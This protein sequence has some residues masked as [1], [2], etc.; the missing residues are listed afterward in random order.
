LKI[1][2][3][4]VLLI[5][6]FCLTLSIPG[7]SQYGNLKEKDAIKLTRQA[8]DSVYN[9]NFPAA[10]KLIR[11]LE[12]GLGDY[13][14][15]LILKAFYM[16]WKYRPIKK[17][18]P[19]FPDMEK[20]LNRSIVVCDSI[21]SIRPD[22][23]EATFF[24]LTSHAYLAQLYSENGMNMKALGEA[25]SAYNYIKAG[26]DMVD[27]NPEF[28]FPCGIYNYY[29][30]KYPEENP[31]YKSVIWFFR[32][33]DMAEGI[34]MLKKGSKS[35]LFDNIECY[36]Y[37]FHIY[38]RYEDKPTLAL[39][40]ARFLKDKYPRN[41]IFTSHYIENSIR[42]DQYAGLSPLVEKL[43]KSDSPYFKYLGEIYAGY[44]A[45]MTEKNYPKAIGHYKAA[46]KIGNANDTRLT[47]YDSILFYGMGRTYKKMGLEDLAQV[48]LKQ[49]VK[50]AEYKS[51]RTTAEELLKK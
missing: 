42:M 5:F 35:A 50:N 25:K 51:Y 18:Q 3:K 39:P 13:P 41:L 20:L 7:F 12:D 33:G 26:F 24:K 34:E 19:A 30:E 8:L 32:S 22:D 31:F 23:P 37:L 36:T 27:K 11:Q 10:D 1:Y 28:Y 2:Q 4:S 14:G 40:Y 47:H 16:S 21:L 49:S 15:V 38:L 9:L 6:I 46:D 43:L 45:E 48:S 17:D 44:L 29:R